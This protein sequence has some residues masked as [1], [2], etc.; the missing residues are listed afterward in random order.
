[1]ARGIML[2]SCFAALVMAACFLLHGVHGNGG[3]VLVPS[4]SVSLVSGRNVTG[5]LS[6]DPPPTEDVVV[7]MAL[8]SRGGESEHNFPIISPNRVRI[9]A[10]TKSASF[11]V[12][13]RGEGRYYVQYQVTVNLNYHVKHAESVI[14]V[15][16]ANDGWGGIQFQIGLNMA[17]FGAGLAFFLWRRLCP[18]LRLPFWSSHPVGLFEKINYDQLPPGKFQSKYGVALLHGSSL[19]DRAR[20][21]VSL[22]C[23]GKD[24]IE[25]A[26]LDAALSMR[27]HVDMGHLFLILTVFSCG[28]LMPIHY[29]SGKMDDASDPYL[30]LSFQETTIGNVPLQSHWY[31]GHVAMTYITALCVL[32]LLQRQLDV[33][34]RVNID[35]TR[36]IGHRSVLINSGLPKDMNSFQLRQKLASFLSPDDIKATVVIHD[37]QALYRILDQRVT[38]RNE[39]NRLITTNAQSISGT[40][41]GC[42]RWC[43]GDI[44]CPSAPL[45]AVSYAR[46]L[47]CRSL[48]CPSAA[49]DRGTVQY[50]PEHSGGRDIQ[51][52]LAHALPRDRRRADW[53]Q[54]ELESFP[55]H[56]LDLYAKRQSTGAAFVVFSSMKAKHDF[57]ARVRAAQRRQLPEVAFPWDA[58][59]SHRDLIAASMEE[60]PEDTS[61][62]APL[63][64]R[65]A[66][67]PDDVHW[68]NLTY[69]PQSAKRVCMFVFYQVTTVVIMILFSTPTAVLIYV[70][71]DTHSAVYA[72]FTHD[73]SS[74][75]AKFITSYL[76]SLLLITVNW[77]LLTSLFY[78]T[79]VEPWLSESERMK[80]FLNKG[81]SY[82][83][84]SSIVLPSIGVTAVYL[85]TDQGASLHHGS[86]AAYIERFMFQ[87]CRNFFIAYVCQRAFLGSILQLLRVGERLVYQPWLRARAVTKAEIREADRPWPYYFGYD[88]A[89]VLS[90]FMVTLLGVVLS[91][92]LTPFGALYFYMKF[93]AMKYN[94]VYVHP[95]SAGR[96]HV[97]RSA[98]TIIFICLVLLEFTV[99]VVILEVG[100]KEQFAA[101]VFLMGATIVLYVG[102][103]TCSY[104]LYISSTL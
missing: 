48:C 43:P 101:M 51:A 88:Y 37:L 79:T 60:Q 15:M 2:P 84:L 6:C 20:R 33:G 59:S 81:F 34:K 36:A 11:S 85:A 26:G 38:L 4:G 31:W 3:I 94:L 66:P 8:T 21:F 69:Q 41:P 16:N 57:E 71:L 40:L 58:T 62:L 9:L 95:K 78:L 89:V 83:L 61:M 99:A 46:C 97:A 29:M 14:M 53:I 86:E 92:L 65:A 1:M 23:D 10:G 45:L 25:I 22:P 63:V 17:V 42:V 64:L 56:V 13:G 87:L 50:S 98:Y 74:V 35:S 72:I 30:D 67:E 96:G 54:H 93:V 76:P 75:L 100:R 5:F 47:P 32:K 91:P 7:D 12:L 80:S 77:C 90:T 102:W 28:V 19:G 49:A 27:L 55:S 52:I 103:Y 104:L 24:I 39:Y 18:R 82:L 44:C 73:I 68:P 70:K